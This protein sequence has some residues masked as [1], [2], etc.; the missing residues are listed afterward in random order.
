MELKNSGILLGFKSLASGQVSVKMWRTEVRFLGGYSITTLSVTLDAVTID[1]D[2]NATV[3]H[4]NNIFIPIS[5]ITLE[6]G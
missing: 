3:I 6:R 4:L 1:T 5:L 2:E